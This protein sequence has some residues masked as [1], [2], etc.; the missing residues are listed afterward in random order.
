ME[1]MYD[2]NQQDARDFGT[3]SI[4]LTNGSFVGTG[5]ATPEGRHGPESVIVGIRQDHETRMG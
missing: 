2:N 3:T 5:A 4:N 1:L